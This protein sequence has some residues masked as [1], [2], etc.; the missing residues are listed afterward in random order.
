MTS[1]QRVLAAIDRERPD[2][3]P[4]DLGGSTVTGL[5]WRVYDGL[6][7]LL[8]IEAET[9]IVNQVSQMPWMDEEALQRLHI[10]TRPVFCGVGSRKP[11]YVREDGAI[12]DEWETVR[13]AAEGK[14][15]LVSDGPFHGDV[16]RADLERFD[17]PDADDPGVIEGMGERARRLHGETDYAVVV[18]LPTGIVHLTQ[19]LRGFDNWLIDSALDERLFTDLMTRVTDIWLGRARMVLEAVADCADVVVVADDVAIQTGTLLSPDQHRRLVGPH[20]RRLIEFVR[21][22]TDA[23]LLFHTCGDCAELIPD[24]IEYGVQALNP[25]QIAGQTADTAWLKREFGRDLCFWGAIDTQHVLPH[26]SADDVRAEVRRRIDD[27]ADGGGYVVSAVH[28]IQQE[29]PAENVLAMCDE[30]YRYGCCPSHSA[31]PPPCEPD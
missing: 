1:R 25:I 28:N 13:T 8:G 17:W 9:R 23:R 10:D 31:S 7:A 4:I 22:S 5:H 6:K 24:L 3:V 21:S 29:V 20:H 30:A 2:C 27:L 12:I 19:F 26:G 11:M 14:P 15:Y 16:T 18:G